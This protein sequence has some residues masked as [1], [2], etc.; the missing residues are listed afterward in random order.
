MLTD[1]P[2]RTRNRSAS[3]KRLTTGQ[4]QKR[5]ADRGPAE[6]NR[7][8]NHSREVTT[9][10]VK[11]VVAWLLLAPV[12]LL[13]ALTLI[14]LGWR[15]LSNGHVWRTVEFRWFFIGV[16]SWAGTYL[17]AGLRPVKL[18]VFG[19]ESSH[20]L[21]AKLSG[22][23]IY[24]GNYW[25]AEGGYVE[26]SKTN[27]LIAL[28]PYLLP[29][30]SLVVLAGF[31]LLAL[32]VDLQQPLTFDLAARRFVVPWECPLFFLLGGTWAFHITYTVI[33]LHVTDQSDLARDGELFSLLLIFVTN[34]ALILVV[35]VLA[36]R[37]P[38]LGWFKA[39]QCWLGKMRWLV[40]GL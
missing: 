31:G 40:P 6:V 20:W 37:D 17:L 13:T 9:F 8:A 25:S 29:F 2:R 21:M 24:G 12:A 22:A 5:A 10:H 14:D 23:K 34:A 7:N 36:S 26:T 39:W 1:A 15:L 3:N 16:M 18:Y 27:T 4:R 19:H 28:A 11:N 38:E 32:F 33:T 35:F 30:Y